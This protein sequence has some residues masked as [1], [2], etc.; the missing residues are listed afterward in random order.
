MSVPVYVDSPLAISA[1]EIFR[2][3]LDCYDEE[4]RS[5]VE[6]GDNPLDFA[7]LQFTR[8][9]DESKA[10]NERAGSSIIISASGMCEAGRIKHHLKHN[11]W[12]P[13]STVLFVGYQAEGTL[14]RRL[15][16]DV[17]KVKIF[18]EEIT[19]NAKIEMI[20]GYS[21]HADRDGLLSWIG[22]MRQKPRKIFIVHG[23]DNSIQDFA[24]AI[25][26]EFGIETIIPSRDE[27]Y[28]I[29]RERVYEITTKT[30]LV[31]IARRFKRL[32]VLDMLEKLREELD[33]ASEIVIADLKKE[34]DDTVV[35]SIMDRLKSIEKSIVDMMK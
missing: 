26:D 9:P 32:E 19:V 8:T 20:E 2:N 31:S 10:L 12:R 15:L 17:K 22:G 13:E 24:K 23:E 34:T 11:L 1:T 5:Y 7:G 21:G 16:D 29:S 14:G 6:N 4:A 33:E 18:G 30:E 28:E 35:D 27:T 25:S 3:N